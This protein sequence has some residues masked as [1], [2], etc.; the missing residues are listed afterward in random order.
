MSAR[1]V[2]ESGAYG[3]MCLAVSRIEALLTAPVG[4]KGLGTAYRLTNQYLLPGQTWCRAEIAPETWMRVPTFEPYWAPVAV[5]KRPYEPE[6]LR[7]LQFLRKHLNGREWAFLDCGANF[8]YWSAIVSGPEFGAKAAAIEA[9]PSTYQRL[10]ETA[11]LNLNRFD[12]L[13]YA[14]TDRDGGVVR[15]EK[16]EAR[17]HATARVCEQGDGVEVQSISIDGLI[18][19]LGWQREDAL[20]IK[21]DVEGCETKALAGAKKMR[22]QV[23]EHLWIYEDHGS[24]G[25]CANTAAFL[26]EGYAVYYVDR[27]GAIS[28]VTE[29]DDV[30]RVKLNPVRGY[31]FVAAPP[32][33]G[34]SAAMSR[35]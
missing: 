21:L 17:L 10:L 22:R 26:S 4:K 28:K 3:A 23:P 27:V 9:S 19:K 11:R 20:I 35:A 16:L 18:E 14:L 5:G 25:D 29:L 1:L 13:Q 24:E 7:L 12:T 15:F 6:I 32:E 2:N 34:F 30:R 33:S 8:G 31:N